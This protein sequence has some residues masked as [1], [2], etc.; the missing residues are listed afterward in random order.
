MIVVVTPNPA[1]DTTYDVAGFEPGLVLRVDAPAVR[2]GGKGVNVARVLTQLGE[3]A[4]SVST[5]G[6]GPNGA[7]FGAELTRSGIRHDL[8]P[9]LADTRRSVAIVDTG[10]LT[11]VMNE[12]GA[13]L[14]DT[15]AEAL[16]DA[17]VA[18]T[19]DADALVCSGSLPP[20]LPPT[21]I[22]RLV[23]A[24]RSAGAAAIV[25]ATGPALI[26]AC[27]AGADAVKPNAEEL[28][29]TVGD[30]DVVAGARRL[31][32]EGAGLVVVTL[33]ADGMLAVS[34]D[35]AGRVVRA[36]LPEAL[37]GNPTGAGDAA[38]AAIAACFARGQREP[39]SVLRQAVAWSGAAVRHPLAGSLADGWEELA[40]RVII[41]ES[42]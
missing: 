25:D 32:T 10:G 6:G 35:D 3:E 24:A 14:T 2:A 15:E 16:L 42:A 39:G 19:T 5:V 18:A 33:G 31:I 30:D 26:A 9:T 17:A 21:A 22:A 1:L 27:R 13:A 11:T 29:E 28:R 38:V 8:T 41:E 40:T 4:V 34:A 20:G 7:E 23:A 12:R 36:R 37:D